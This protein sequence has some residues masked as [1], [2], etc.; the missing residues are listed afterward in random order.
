[1]ATFDVQYGPKLSEALADDEHGPRAIRVFSELS[2]Q[3]ESNRSK[4]GPRFSRYF[5]TLVRQASDMA[6]DVIY[7]HAESPIERI[8]LGT[9]VLSF[10]RS[11][12]TAFLF[13]PPCKDA[14]ASIQAAKEDHQRVLKWVKA[15]NTDTRRPRDQTLPEWLSQL[16]KQAG[17]PIPNRAR[18]EAEAVLAQLG[19]FKSFHFTPQARFP[20]LQ[21]GTRSCRVDLL[22]W[23]PGSKG[24]GL[25]VECDGYKFHRTK[26]RF[27][28][29]R[30][31]DRKFL[32][33]GYVVVRYSG[34]EIVNRP[35]ETSYD[36]YELLLKREKSL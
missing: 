13:T 29:D 26:E 16:E 20:D 36:L 1:M 31:R 30:K 28:R 24:R 12:P 33:R 22:V 5:G 9:L 23:L 19:Y 27:E 34:T 32:E 15:F 18:L 17:E 8:F 6:S 3:E 7:R 25:V 2:I 14:P 21:I 4:L 11:D 10:L 35:V